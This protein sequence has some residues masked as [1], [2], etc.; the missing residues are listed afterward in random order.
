MTG[1]KINEID[2]SKCLQNNLLLP[3]C[4]QEKKVIEYCRLKQNTWY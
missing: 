3:K 2:V 4:Q 1:K